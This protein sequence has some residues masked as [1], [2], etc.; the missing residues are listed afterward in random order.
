MNKIYTIEQVLE[1]NH[2]VYLVN[3]ACL[4]VQADINSYINK[5]EYAFHAPEVNF[6]VGSIDEAEAI[7]IHGCQVT[8]L[9]ILHAFKVAEQYQLDYPDKRVYIAGCLAERGD[10]AFPTNVGRVKQFKSMKPNADC[11][12]QNVSKW[13]PP[14]WVKNFDEDGTWDQPGSLFRDCHP[15]RMSSGCKFNCEYCTIKQVRGEYKEY[16]PDLGYMESQMSKPNAVLVADSPSAKQL[17]HWI[18]YALPRNKRISIRNVEPQVAVKCMN[19]IEALANQDCLDVF[20]CPIQHTDIMALED[21]N[22]DIIATAK[23]I[24]LCKKL[25]DKGVVTAT[26]VIIDYKGFADPTGLN[27]FHHVNWNPYWDGKFNRTLAEKR[28]KHYITDGQERTFKTQ[29]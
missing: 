23:V 26:N 6:V 10:I 4:T 8:D 16:D 19:K 7:V 14:F 24:K 5:Q 17:E 18:D 20:H 22:R 29:D 13:L 2:H 1:L 27:M 28:F 12:K 11:S 3:A 25:V 9:S 15:I 21:M